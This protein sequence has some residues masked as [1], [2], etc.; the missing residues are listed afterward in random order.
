METDAGHL[1]ARAFLASHG[2]Y[3]YC[4]NVNDDP[5]LV[6]ERDLPLELLSSL[7]LDVEQA[8]VDVGRRTAVCASVLNSH[9]FVLPPGRANASNP[10]PAATP[11][12]RLESG[13]G[14][15]LSFDETAEVATATVCLAVSNTGTADVTTVLAALDFDLP[16]GTGSTRS[17]LFEAFFLWADVTGE[18]ERGDLA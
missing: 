10:P 5:A 4:P 12:A 8:A 16:L 14:L 15:G 3:R 18:G 6:A 9:N 1:G 7:L 13:K 17:G 2:V 11:H